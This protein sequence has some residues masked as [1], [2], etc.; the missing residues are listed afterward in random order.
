MNI[1]KRLGAVFTLVLALTV[2]IAVAAIWR[3]NTIGNETSE[4][5]A[6]PL[7]KERLMSEWHTQT[8]AAVR[9]TAAIVKSN[10]PSLA[11][12]FKAD[13]ARTSG[14]SSELIRQI[15]PLLES[16]E[17]RALFKR[18]GELRKAYTQAKD[19][20]I[21]ARTA[22]DADESA[23]ILTDEYMPAAD[24]YESTLDKLVRMQQRRIDAIAADIQA[25]NQDS[26]RMIG[27]LAAAAVTLGALCSWVLTRGIVRPIREAVELAETVASGDLTRRIDVTTNDETGAL[28]RALRHMNDSLVNIVTEVRGSTETIA[29][30]S[31]EIAAGNMDLSR[32]T[33]QQA[34]SLEET[35]ASMEQITGTVRQNAGNAG[36]ANQLAIAASKVAT[37][38]GAVVG[39]VVTTMGSI[40]ESS[41]KIV[42][43]I[44]VIDGIAFQT[45]ILA[46]NAAV[47]AARAG[48]QG[49]GFAVVASEVRT[50]AQ[51]SAA[52][53]REIKGLIGDSVQ[54]VDAGTRL[55]DQA[56][57]TM[58]QVVE[59]I[60][61]VTEIM[62]DIT[63]ATQEQ[64]AG[65]EQVNGSIGLMDEA[66]Q[67]N[68]ALVEQSAA[69]AGAM[70]DQAGKLAQVVRVFKLEGT[71]VAVAG[72]A[73]PAPSRGTA[74][75]L[76]PA[77]RM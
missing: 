45:N 55:V 48:E 2:V 7:V 73:V 12:F 68:A 11:E 52:A 60:R 18:I 25:D 53:A 31:G 49:R 46:L 54:K 65:I 66:T 9:R 32:R 47:E 56:G 61:R 67:Q 24:T 57:A 29:G 15:E 75:R 38:G 5:M 50:L 64:A 58:E 22:G 8:F 69:A 74:M 76:A 77:A 30:A 28:L 71:A 21:A 16:D 19:K 20:A 33:E 1:G 70:Q 26:A 23:R 41:R 51:R 37:E 34:A 17:E 44:G 13:N 72:P 42:D 10:D 3:M 40:N 59:S 27:I 43:I 39:Q 6:I 63:Q 36:Q 35:A 4:M 14:R 62:A